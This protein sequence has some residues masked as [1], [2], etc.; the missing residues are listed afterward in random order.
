M[1]IDAIF[2][3]NDRLLLITKAVAGVGRS[4]LFVC[5][6]VFAHDI[7]KTDADH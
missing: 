1:L 4:P 7:S 2:V 3:E 6:S 5:A